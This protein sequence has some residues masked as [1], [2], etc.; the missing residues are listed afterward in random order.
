M[1]TCQACG[2]VVKDRK[3]VDHI[4]PRRLCTWTQALDPSNL[5][6]LCYRCHTIKTELEQHIAAQP[7]GDTK[8]MHL[9]CEWWAKVIRE[10]IHTK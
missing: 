8:L 7:N 4:I 9:S 5:W 3:L 2:E 6:T 10:R 1:A